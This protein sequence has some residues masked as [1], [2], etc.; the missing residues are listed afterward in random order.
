MTA[1][2]VSLEIHMQLW[3]CAYTSNS[4]THHNF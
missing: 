2:E 1:A 4:V 3:K